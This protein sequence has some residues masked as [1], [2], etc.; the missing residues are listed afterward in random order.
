[1][2]RPDADHV[3]V[4]WDFPKA[5]SVR[6][7]REEA[8]RRDNEAF[9]AW[10]QSGLWATADARRW[11]QD[12][13]QAMYQEAQAGE[14]EFVR[15][16]YERTI[17]EHPEL[18]G[19]PF[20]SLKQALDAMATAYEIW[21]SAERDIGVPDR[22]KE[23]EQVKLSHPFLRR[24]AGWNPSSQTF[25]TPVPGWLRDELLRHPDAAEALPFRDEALSPEA[26]AAAPV[27]WPPAPPPRTPPAPGSRTE[28][29]LSAW[30]ASDAL[31]SLDAL[32]GWATDLGLPSPAETPKRDLCRQ[33][34]AKQAW[35][36]PAVVEDVPLEY[37]DID[38]VSAQPLLNPV[39][40]SNSY[41]YNVS[42][43]N[44]L[45][46]D[47]KER[48]RGPPR[49]PFTRGELA[50][51][52]TPEPAVRDRVAAAMRA[53]G[54]DLSDP[55]YAALLRAPLTT[56]WS[57]P[58]P[59]L[60]LR[61]VLKRY[62]DDW[63]VQNQIPDAERQEVLQ[64][65]G[66]LEALADEVDTAVAA[67]VAGGPTEALF[68]V[69]HK[70]VDDASR[71]YGVAPPGN[72]PEQPTVKVGARVYLELLLFALTELANSRVATSSWVQHLL[73]DVRR[74]LYRVRTQL[75]PITPTLSDTLLTDEGLLSAGPAESG[76]EAL[77][78]GSPLLRRR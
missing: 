31:E 17:A 68:P 34:A 4:L 37:D 18:N 71:A 16:T 61:T 54:Y 50:S 41:T 38:T 78:L 36:V 74:A 75:S 25:T 19:A 22:V 6:E 51:T 7:A 62:A 55:E 42:T 8:R 70:L 39:R 69:S 60:A 15:A 9:A 65:I 53:R 23:I 56:G 12:L 27:P 40:A 77:P 47:A 28:P 57:G 33:I 24:A 72:A 21:A 76:E 14:V 1:M 46:G 48:D 20:S 5:P 52:W 66:K 64:T 30:C 49:S 59:T 35:N 29:G 67:V 44:R 13:D 63:A 43:L 45:W 58:L 26:E 3:T 2:Q 32:R 11:L 73:G 10:P